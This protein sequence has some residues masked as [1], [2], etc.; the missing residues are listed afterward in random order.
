MY[1]IVITFVAPLTVQYDN[2]CRHNYNLIPPS[3]STAT[4]SICFEVFHI[5]TV[6]N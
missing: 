3:T 6:T 4:Q 5:G 1:L 2:Q